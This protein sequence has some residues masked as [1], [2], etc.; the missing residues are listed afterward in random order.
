MNMNPRHLLR[1]ARWA[2]NPP[3]KRR[4]KLVFTVIAICALLFAV[5]R[6]IGWPDMLTLEK[7]PKLRVKTP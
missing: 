4:V 7:T 3:S 6:W 2:H 1:M 5:E